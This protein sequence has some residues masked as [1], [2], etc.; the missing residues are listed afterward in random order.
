MKMKRINNVLFISTTAILF[1]VSAISPMISGTNTISQDKD[2]SQDLD[3]LLFYA[4][5]DNPYTTESAIR[6]KYLHYMQY[7]DDSQNT[8]FPVEKM[9]EN[10]IYFSDSF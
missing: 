7:I 6:D 9:L 1:I 8:T 4:C 5:Y 10:T 2:F 3:D